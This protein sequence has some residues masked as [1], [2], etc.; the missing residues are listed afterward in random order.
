MGENENEDGKHEIVYDRCGCDAK[1]G[2][3]VCMDGKGPSGGGLIEAGKIIASD[4]G[5][6]LDAVMAHMMGVKPRDIPMLRIAADRGLGEID[7]SKLEVDGPLE[8]IED[9]RM[10]QTFAG[11][12]LGSMLNRFIFP[13]L[14]TKPSFDPKRCTK[15]KACF[16]VCPVK[17]ISWD[18]GPVLDKSKC[19]SCFCCMESCLFDA[20]GLGGFLYRL[21]DALSGRI[22]GAPG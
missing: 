11:G 5:V 15:C 13:L 4:N 9:F 8:V 21:R 2:P 10:P 14:R 3:V 18:D 19:I 17:A 16:K 12:F 1:R 7:I 22:T 6:S 20:V